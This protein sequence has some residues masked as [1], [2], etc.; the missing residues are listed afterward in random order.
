M[1]R[2]QFCKGSVEGSWGTCGDCQNWCDN[3]KAMNVMVPV[4]L[5]HVRQVV[6]HQLTKE[7]P[8]FEKNLREMRMVLLEYV[9]MKEE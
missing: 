9:E 2:C 5:V 3:L 8:Y 4:L 1:G 6:S 7:D